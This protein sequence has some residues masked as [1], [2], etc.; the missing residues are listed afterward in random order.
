[1][2]KIE[3]TSKVSL[4]LP[5]RINLG[6]RGARVPSS[7]LWTQPSSSPTAPKGPTPGQKEPVVP[8]GTINKP[9]RTAKPPTHSLERAKYLNKPEPLQKAQKASLIQEKDS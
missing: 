7:P 8:T 6:R 2:S 9:P 5:S 4:K 1:M 3:T